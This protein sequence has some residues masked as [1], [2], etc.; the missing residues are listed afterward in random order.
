MSRLHDL[1]LQQGRQSL[2][3]DAETNQDHRAIL[4][5]A[6]YLSDESND[7][8]F[9]FAGWA[10]SGLPHRRIPDEREWR[11]ETDYVT[12][13][14]EPGRRPQANGENPHVGVPYGTRARLIMLYL[15]TEALRTNSREIALGGSLRAWMSRLGIAVGGRSLKE[16][17][18]QADR[19]SR[20][21]LTFHMTRNGRT[22]LV[23]QNIVD[24]AMFL[25]DTGT[26]QGQGK[27]F[28]EVAKLSEGFFD[29]LKKHPV[30]VEEAAIRQLNNNS[31][32]LDIY[33]WLA[34]RLHSLKGP[35]KLTWT[36]IFKQFGA[37]FSLMKHFKPEFLNNLQLALAV[38]PAANVS[39]DD[40]DSSLTIYPSPSPVAKRLIA[41]SDNLQHTG[42][43]AANLRLAAK[44]LG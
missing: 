3:T 5:A 6:N 1:L 26:T 25:D 7:A 22:S 8:Y 24:T 2:L 31:M 41:V 13:L 29:Q 33:C 27:L 15:Q 34:Y 44:A 42:G 38:Y 37:G 32:A 20:C 28:L 17:R 12:L 23:N 35:T 11:I 16:V 30:P 21:R 14:V 19:I 9:L 36:A 10:L 43:S 4:A 40:H 18:D 39:L